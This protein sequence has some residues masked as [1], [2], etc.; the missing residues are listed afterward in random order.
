MPTCSLRVPSTATSART[1]TAY[2][3]VITAGCPRCSARSTA[4]IA[5]AFTAMS[6]RRA[7]FR[8]A[9]ICAML[10]LAA[11]SGSGALPSNSSVSAASRSSKAPLR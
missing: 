11:L 1:D 5:A 9:L 6:R 7:R 8:A 2:A 4:W 10:N 3:A